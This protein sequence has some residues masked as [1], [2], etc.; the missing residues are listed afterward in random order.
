MKPKTYI[1]LFFVSGAVAIGAGF[2]LDSSVST[3][4]FETLGY[5]MI[6]GCFGLFVGSVFQARASQIV[7]LR[8]RGTKYV[9]LFCA[10]LAIFLFT[11]EEARYKIVQDEPNLA[12]VALGLHESRTPLIVEASFEDYGVAKKLDKRPL[13]FPFLVS[14]LH[15]IFGFNANH[16]FYLNLFLTAALL[17]L[18]YSTVKS[19]SAS[20]FAA[21]LSI[22]LL[23]SH[24]II[25]QNS[26][27][28]GFELLN[29]V[30]ILVVIKAAQFYLRNPDRNS[31]AVLITS[32]LLLAQ[33]R[34]ESALYVIPT[35]IVVLLG[36][37][38]GKKII[39]SNYLLLA[40]LLLLP[41]A[42]QNAYIRSEPKFWQLPKGTESAFGFEYLKTNLANAYHF[43]FE[44]QTYVPSSPF[45]FAIGFISLLALFVSSIVSRIGKRKLT[46]LS[47][48]TATLLYSFM[49]LLSFA[50]LMCYHWGNINDPQASRLAI[51][52]LL[53]LSIAFGLASNLLM[54]VKP[55]LKWLLL[56]TPSLCWAI[57]LPI[58]NSA[59]Y[60]KNNPYVN[61]F[62]WT[63]SHL[64]L[65]KTENILIISNEVRLYSSIDLNSIPIK[66][67]IMGA[68]L[69][70][71][72]L[73][74]GTYDA[75]YVVQ[76]G[77]YQI[78][79]DSISTHFHSGQEL[80]PAFE[81]EPI[82]TSSF[83]PYNTTKLSR[84]KKINIDKISEAGGIKKYR[85]KYLTIED[86]PIRPISH[87][88]F[89]EWKGTLP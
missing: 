74:I 31:L 36:F 40:P 2:L 87:Q 26:S 15:D 43:F 13:F 64:D 50:L 27:G 85:S 71:H 84:L 46:F 28:G 51:P 76:S 75:I 60:T 83:H 8:E 61:R 82:A 62:N 49:V 56:L 70:D 18:V 53:L 22:A 48:D 78:S 42:W 88:E 52:F 80:G 54:A 33:T 5:W 37:S 30:M 17:L 72:H 45:V 24:P 81:L 19:I 32:T 89:L 59:E 21:W 41:V 67:A 79:N 86:P 20:S 7:S 35:G 6:L 14:A 29:A 23:C 63:L 12:N 25:A 16:P 38:K 47:I 69:I 10:L 77:F 11:R 57:T 9:I 1:S 34:Y 4:L 68:L 73:K 58:I 39:F 44:P 65:K 55:H 3:K 66:R